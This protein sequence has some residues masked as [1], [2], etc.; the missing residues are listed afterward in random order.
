MNLNKQRQL[1]VFKQLLIICDY[2]C[3]KLDNL[4]IALTHRSVGIPNNERLEFLGDSVLNFVVTNELY[5][6]F[7]NANEGDLTRFRARLVCGE[8]LSEIAKILKLGDFLI[9]GLG[10]RRTEGHKRV[11][12][13]ADALE[14]II[15][16]MFCDMGLEF[17]KK[18]F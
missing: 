9:L 17:V 15:G 13:L 5:R 6:R 16:V 7:Q 12:I 8:K 4:Q 14:A 18:K 11:S 2:P 1:Q 3:D 10:E